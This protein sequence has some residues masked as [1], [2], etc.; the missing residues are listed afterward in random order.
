MWHNNKTLIS[1]ACGSI[2]LL[3]GEPCFEAISIIGIVSAMLIVALIAIGIIAYRCFKRSKMIEVNIHLKNV[4]FISAYRVLL[5][6]I[7]GL[8]NPDFNPIC[9]I[10]DL[11]FLIQFLHFNP[12]PKN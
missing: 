9:W 6:W 2:P 4:V 10:L 12:N 1:A 3:N 5:D 11:D 7:A 8:I